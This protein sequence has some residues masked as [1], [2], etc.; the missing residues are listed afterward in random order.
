MQESISW[1]G[2]ADST[3]NRNHPSTVDHVGAMDL[4]GLMDETLRLLMRGKKLA[5]LQQAKEVMEAR[6][7]AEDNHS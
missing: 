1:G 4:S 6:A 3:E 5:W 2:G 7:E